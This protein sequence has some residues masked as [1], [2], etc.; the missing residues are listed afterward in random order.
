[1]LMAML[2]GSPI[3]AQSNLR[4]GEV[5]KEAQPIFL[6][7]GMGIN[8]GGLGVS[9]ELPVLQTFS[10]FGNAGIGGWGWKLGGG[11]IY[12]P[13]HIPYKSSYSVSYYTA[14][15]LKDFKTN[16]WIEPN[17]VEE[18][19]DIDL[20]RAGTVN[21][22]YS[23]NLKVGRSSKF[24]FSGGYAIPITNKPYKLHDETVV[25]T[26]SSKQFLEFMQPGGVVIGVKFMVGI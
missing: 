10:F 18:S 8:D 16:L 19:V 23:Y 6:G 9:I 5:Q 14:S 3:T 2:S 22:V 7:F 12:Y 17:G 26:E 11:I 24:V 25:L 4:Y 13:K 20:Y 21:L 15:G 1:M